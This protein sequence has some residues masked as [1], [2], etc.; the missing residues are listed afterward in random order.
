MRFCYS[1]LFTD[2]SKLYGKISRRLGEI[3]RELLCRQKDIELVEGH[4]QSVPCPF[5]FRDTAKVQCVKYC[6]FFEG[7]KCRHTFTLGV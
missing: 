5:M 2:P 6:R 1:D 4:A 3:I 7:Q